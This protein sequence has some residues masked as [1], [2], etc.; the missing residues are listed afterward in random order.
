[1]PKAHS[2]YRK[3]KYPPAAGC[4]SAST[5]LATVRQP[6]ELITNVAKKLSVTLLSLFVSKGGKERKVQ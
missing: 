1:V 6:E 3:E 2:K 4:T 5:I